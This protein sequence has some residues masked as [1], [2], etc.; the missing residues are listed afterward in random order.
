MKTALSKKEQ[1]ER[2]KRLAFTLYVDN[3]FEQKV[4]AEITGISER[5]IG[6]W[7]KQGNWDEEKRTANLGPEKQMR[8]IMKIY[9]SMLTAIE[10]R[11]PPI[12]DSKETDILNKLADSVKKLQ[13]DLTMFVKSEVGKQFISYI[14][15]THGQ[16]QAIE[17]VELWHEY[18]MATS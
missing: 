5:S 1:M 10:S 3:G 7:K 11:T 15:Q 9:D 6:E 8:R 18:L 2:S 13:A 12:P 17:A 14:Q 4:I 16:A